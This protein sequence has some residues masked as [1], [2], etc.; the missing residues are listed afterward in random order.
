MGRLGC[1]SESGSS[2]GCRC[3]GVVAGPG[4]GGGRICRS[5]LVAL[6]EALSRLPEL[7]AECG[8]PRAGPGPR[9]L[10]G[11]VTARRVIEVPLVEAALEAR[12]AAREVLASWASLVRGCGGASGGPLTEVPELVDYLLAHLDLLVRHEAARDF[13]GEMSELVSLTLNVLENGPRPRATLGNCV[14]AGCGGR[15]SA[16]TDRPVVECD[17]G[18]Q[19]A[20]HEWLLL[21]RLER[22]R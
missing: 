6:R 5:C 11:R 2:A 1:E 16:R 21:G 17:R 18:H 3:G 12:A 7:Y 8:R 19:W 9:D 10:V 4:G 14:R 20:V 15:L 22:R 13:A